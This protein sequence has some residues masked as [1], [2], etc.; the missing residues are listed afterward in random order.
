MCKLCER[1]FILVFK[2]YIQPEFVLLRKQHMLNYRINPYKQQIMRFGGH[3]LHN[4][5]L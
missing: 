2:A 5:G 4:L 3:F 1:Y